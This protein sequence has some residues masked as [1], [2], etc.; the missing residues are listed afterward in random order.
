MNSELYHHLRTLDLVSRLHFSSH[1]RPLCNEHDRTRKPQSI[2]SSLRSCEE[3]VQIAV[4]PYPL[5]A[6]R[7][8][9]MYRARIPTSRDLDNVLETTR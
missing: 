7:P 6:I 3:E 9:Y 1:R 5:R 4:L 8:G 2:L